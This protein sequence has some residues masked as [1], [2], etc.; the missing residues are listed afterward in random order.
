[1]KKDKKLKDSI[2]KVTREKYGIEINKVSISRLSLH[3]KNSVSV[4]AKMQ[5]GQLK[6]SIEISSK[7]LKNSKIMKNSANEKAEKILAEAEAEA[8]KIRSVVLVKSADL[9]AQYEKDQDFALFLR[10][11]DAIKETT[12]SKTTFFINPDIPPFDLFK[13][14]EDKKESND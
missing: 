8:K 6:K 1:M 7:A 12:K 14:N 2:N 9:F 10:K 4:L 13:K 5:Q 3:E 11:L